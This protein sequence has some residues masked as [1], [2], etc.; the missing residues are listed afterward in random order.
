MEGVKEDFKKEIIQA[1]L[2]WRQHFQKA[3]IHMSTIVR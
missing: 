2:R 3:K 1:I